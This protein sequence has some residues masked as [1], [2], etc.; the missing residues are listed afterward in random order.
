MVEIERQKAALIAEI[1]RARSSFRAATTELNASLDLGTM[2]KNFVAKH[3]WLIVGSALGTGILA[4]LIG[5]RLN[6]ISRI[7]SAVVSGTAGV[8]RAG[9]K[10][11]LISSLFSAVQPTIARIVTE[12]LSVFLKDKAPDIFKAFSEPSRPSTPSH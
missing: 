12:K 8:A 10:S 11:L 6:P 2:S 1:E 4:A 5:T 3:S 7:G 9:F